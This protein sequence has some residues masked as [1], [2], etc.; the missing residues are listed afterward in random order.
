MKVGQ[1]IDILN[2]IPSD[3]EIYLNT[4]EST[5]NKSLGSVTSE[6]VYGYVDTL[7]SLIG[8]DG[9]L[10]SKNIVVLGQRPFEPTGGD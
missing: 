9:E 4:M 10:K 5:F 6:R 1:L 3:L 8:G 2:D 7:A